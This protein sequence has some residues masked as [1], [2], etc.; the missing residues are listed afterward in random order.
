M[1]GVYKCVS[2]RAQ[3]RMLDACSVSF[4]FYYLEAGS[5]PEPGGVLEAS[6]HQ[7]SSC[8][9]HPQGFSHSAGIQTQPLE[10]M[11]QALPRIPV[12]SWSHCWD[13]SET[14]AHDTATPYVLF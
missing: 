11:Q 9:R 6:E 14:A 7:E 4:P 3:K 1:Y 12:D 10:L 5:F 2:L 8:V 13:P